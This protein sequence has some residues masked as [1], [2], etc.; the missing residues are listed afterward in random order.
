MRQAGTR[1]WGRRVRVSESIHC[2]A[3]CLCRT[4]HFRVVWFCAARTHASGQ[5]WSPA[6][7]NLC[8]EQKQ[9][10]WAWYKKLQ[11]MNTM[12]EFLKQYIRTAHA[13]T[14]VQDKL[15]RPQSAPGILT[16]NVSSY[17]LQRKCCATSPSPSSKGEKKWSM[18][19]AIFI[20]TFA[21]PSLFS[22]CI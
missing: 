2:S 18:L 16:Y 12:T 13:I 3:F 7:S 8:S 10:L 19:T 15:N 22:K 20:R 9:Q 5:H 11:R 14:A 4:Y 17:H 1:A 6:A 21:Q